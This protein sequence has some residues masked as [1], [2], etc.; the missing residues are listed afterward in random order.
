[1]DIYIYIYIYIY[2]YIWINVDS[3]MSP[4]ARPMGPKM[5]AWV[6][7]PG[8]EVFPVPRALPPRGWRIASGRDILKSTPFCFKALRPGVALRP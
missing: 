3:P 4:R 8:P 2:G 5:A 6:P 7:G 1:M